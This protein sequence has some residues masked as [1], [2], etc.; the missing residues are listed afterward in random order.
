MDALRNLVQN[1]YLKH[2][3]EREGFVKAHLLE[4]IDDPHFAQLITYWDSQRAIENARKTGS[5]KQTVQSLAS[6][7]P[8]VRIQRQGYIVTVDTTQVKVAVQDINR[9]ATTW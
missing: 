9:D 4:A 6:H 1:Q 7:M 5:L 3:Q 2:V 8:G